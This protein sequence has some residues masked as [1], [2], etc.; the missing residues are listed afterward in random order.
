MGCKRV[1]GVLKK[2]LQKQRKFDSRDDLSTIVRRQGIADTIG[3][4]FIPYASSSAAWK[5][6]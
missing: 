1:C 2:D 4:T 3:S 5:W 6:C